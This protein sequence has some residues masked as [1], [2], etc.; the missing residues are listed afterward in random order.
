MG[1]S[2]V[3]CTRGLAGRLAFGHVC[4]VVE[5]RSKLF[6]I[7]FLQPTGGAKML[8][9]FNRRRWWIL[10]IV[11]LAY[12]CFHRYTWA[13]W[14]PLVYDFGLWVFFTDLLP[15]R[16]DAV[17]SAVAASVVLDLFLRAVVVVLGATLNAFMSY[18][19][20]LTAFEGM[21]SLYF[22][23]ILFIV[24]LLRIVEGDSPHVLATAGEESEGFFGRAALV[25]WRFKT[26]L[27]KRTR[28]RRREDCQ[29]YTYRFF[30]YSR[31]DYFVLPFVLALTLG[32]ELGGVVLF[33]E[34]WTFGTFYIYL[35]SVFFLVAL[36]DKEHG[37]EWIS[38]L[39]FF[40]FWVVALAVTYG[41]GV[42]KL[43]IERKH[44]LADY[45]T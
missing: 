43:K 15:W 31:L 9:D 2:R 18:V 29:A 33:G 8:V 13:I 22:L 23:V 20:D 26:A 30:S 35:V 41:V 38:P 11:H 19:F 21:R 3:M 37:W 14:V 28:A 4:D 45:F 5:K 6:S 42:G 32:F 25:P 34:P 1:A 40:V 10:V 24:V 27:K 12:L 17:P 7:L 44:A 39:L 36:A 16:A